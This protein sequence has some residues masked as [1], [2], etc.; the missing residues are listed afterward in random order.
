MGLTLAHPAHYEWLMHGD[1]SVHFLGWHLFRRGPWTWPIGAAPLLG[2]PIGTSVGLTDSIPLLAVPFKLLDLVLPSAFQY[3]GLWILACFVLQGVFGVLLMQ[4]ATSR[5]S[6]QVA[7]AALFVMSPPLLFRLG[8]PALSA[9]WLFLAGLWLLFGPGAETPSRWSLIGWSAL[10]ATAAGTHPYVTLMVLTMAAAA[11]ARQ[12]LAA[13]ARALRIGLQ[14]AVV[15]AGAGIVLWQSGYFIVGGSEDLQVGGLSSYSMNLLSPLIPMHGSRL[16]SPGPFA[17]ATQGQYEGYAYLGAGTLAL[18]IV[19]VGRLFVRLPP[20]RPRL[21]HAQ[22]VPLVLAASFLT[23]MALSPTITLGAR[24]VFEYDPVLWGPLSVFRASGRMFWPVYYAGVF[25]ILTAVARLRF[26]P[27]LIAMIAA[28]T[29]QAADTSGT[30]SGMRQTRTIAFTNPLESPFWD[31]VPP[32]YDRLVLVPTNVCPGDEA[33]DHRPFSLL[34]GRHGLAINAGMAARYDVGK[35][36]DYCDAF[37][38]EWHEGIIADDALYVVRP[39]LVGTFRASRIRPSVCAVIDGHGAC[40]AADTYRAWQDDFDVLRTSLPPAADLVAF[41]DELDG[42]Y[43]DRLRRPPVQAAASPGDRMDA[44]ARY[45]AYR[46]G[47]CGHTTSLEKTLR[48]AQRAR[49]LR[50]CVSA[51]DVSAL[52]PAN[53]THAFR[54]AL[55]TAYR[56]RNDGGRWITHVDL[57][58]EAVWVLAYVRERLAGRDDRTARDSV[59]AAI[60]AIAGDPARD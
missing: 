58:G 7:G 42:E 26:A 54:Q 28:V 3:I 5:T 43:R 25:G 2:A 4:V 49:E 36:R 11:H 15:I 24:T 27:A 52:P 17:Y 53:E 21:A 55:E 1:W 39:D 56:A 60:R 45:L 12:L 37:A 33:I 32:L 22:Y 59:M 46:L 48:E 29:L 40:V 44:I 50:W 18:A 13:P 38:R 34:A 14:L 57:E 51:P 19:A 31:R 10:A 23:V 16:F 41:F 6:L 30:Y 47:G 35:L 9:H 20:W 8:H